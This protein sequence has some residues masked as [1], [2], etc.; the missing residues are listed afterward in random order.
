[1][2][3]LGNVSNIC[4][5]QLNTVIGEIG[6]RGGEMHFNK[7][8]NRI[9]IFWYQP[10]A[11]LAVWNTAALYRTQTRTSAVAM[12]TKLRYSCNIFKVKAA[13]LYQGQ[14]IKF[15][16]VSAVKELWNSG[17]SFMALASKGNDN[18]LFFFKTLPASEFYLKTLQRWTEMVDRICEKWTEQKWWHGA[19]LIMWYMWAWA[20][21]ENSPSYFLVRPSVK[22]WSWVWVQKEYCVCNI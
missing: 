7:W 20:L 9:F 15:N 16:P 8:K 5:Y 21:E 10:V 22:E 2:A 1:M 11:E 6:G 3:R 4:R 17:F 18:Y 13:T 12:K 19:N 14:Y